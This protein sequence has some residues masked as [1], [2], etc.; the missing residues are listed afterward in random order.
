MQL[1]SFENGAKTR[2]VFKQRGVLLFVFNKMQI[3]PKN[4]RS[5]FA[6]YRI[7]FAT[8]MK[9]FPNGGGEAKINTVTCATFNFRKDE[10]IVTKRR[11]GR[12]K[13]NT[14]TSKVN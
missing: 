8:N 5:R 6:F 3:S 7:G 9:T 13:P 2:R 1:Q 11:R 12:I 14:V 10:K 4:G